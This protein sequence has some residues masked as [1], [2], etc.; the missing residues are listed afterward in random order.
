MGTLFQDVGV[1]FLKVIFQCSERRS[2]NP[3]HLVRIVIVE[4]DVSE[5][6]ISEPGQTKPELLSQ[7][8]TRH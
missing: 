5:E 7:T 4:V 8:D 3:I 6:D 2:K 1:H